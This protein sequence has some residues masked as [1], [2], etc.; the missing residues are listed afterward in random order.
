M[1]LLL[2]AVTFATGEPITPVR[3]DDAL[4]GAILKTCETTK[5]ARSEKLLNGR[6]V[7][8][9]VVVGRGRRTPT[10]TKSERLASSR[11]ERYH[12]VVNGEKKRTE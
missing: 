9:A 1:G 10:K 4:G 8:T 7:N 12:A 6:V 3:G 11:Q 5:L 2:V